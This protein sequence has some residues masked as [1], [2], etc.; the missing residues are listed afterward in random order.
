LVAAGLA[1]GVL[2]RRRAPALL[3][4]WAWFVGTL[5]PVIG[6]VQVGSQS[7]ADRYTYLPQVG[8]LLALF[9]GLGEA[10]AV[11]AGL[12]A[13]AL[14]A[15]P[16]ALAAL[17]A[18]TW[19]QVTRWR[20]SVSLFSHA[21]RVTGENPVALAHLGYA[22]VDQGRTAEGNELIARSFRALPASRATA[23]EG[24]GDFYAS[25]GRKREAAAQYGRALA[26]EPAKRRIRE[27]LQALG[28]VSQEADLPLPPDP[29]R[30]QGALD[31][32]EEG[33][34]LALA[35]RREEAV[36]AY[37]E[38]IRTA[39]GNAEAWNNLGCALAELGRREE[40][41]AAIGEALRLKPD[42]PLAR[43]NLEAIRAGA[44][45]RGADGEPPQSAGVPR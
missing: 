26:I 21:L 30:G 12:R 5:L 20:D 36:S 22:L 35:G 44:R 6:I 34:R 17:A 18:A 25:V 14:A 8:V 9:W 23:F 13:A 2:S 11:R 1:I 29:H 24:A 15:A 4:G 31:P 3:V 37:R 32:Y 43:K 45:Q 7:M 10:G 33:N 38:A 41:V 40:A 19:L 42:H 27:K 28:D 39:P 16:L